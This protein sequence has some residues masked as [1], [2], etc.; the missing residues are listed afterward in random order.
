MEVVVDKWFPARPLRMLKWLSMYLQCLAAGSSI[1]NREAESCAMRP[2][3]RALTK[4]LENVRNLLR[5]QSLRSGLGA[6]RSDL[7]SSERLREAL[8]IF[9]RMFADFELCYVSAMVPVKTLKEYDLQQLVVV[10][11]SETLQ[12]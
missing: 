7:W 9:D 5:E 8:K 1:M 11:F 2:L 6:L 3:A 10:L 4:S 12:R